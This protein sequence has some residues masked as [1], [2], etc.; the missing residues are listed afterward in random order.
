[1]RQANRWADRQTDRPTDRHTYRQM[2]RQIDKQIGHV[3]DKQANSKGSQGTN[4]VN[5]Y[6]N[7]KSNLTLLKLHFNQNFESS[8]HQ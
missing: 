1:M 4:V 6:L 8:L 2:G 5:K 3:I 7:P